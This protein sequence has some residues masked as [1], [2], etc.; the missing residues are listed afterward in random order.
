[1]IPYNH[2]GYQIQHRHELSYTRF[3]NISEDASNVKI[4]EYKR[5]YYLELN[6]QPCSRGVLYARYYCTNTD[7]WLHI[8]KLTLSAL[9][10]FATLGGRA[11][12]DSCE[13]D[14]CMQTV[15]GNSNGAA[16]VRSLQLITLYSLLTRLI[17]SALR[18]GRRQ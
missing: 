14:A 13:L 4:T 2:K 16:D 10:L 11:L 12:A 6:C 17:S 5:T 7:N 1:M 3:L 9:T 15:R 18:T 8:M